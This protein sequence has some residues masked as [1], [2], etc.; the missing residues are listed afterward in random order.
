MCALS[1]GYCSRTSVS[2]AI[3]EAMSTSIFA[4]G[5][6]V[7]RVA[8]AHP[9]KVIDGHDRAAPPALVFLLA[10]QIVIDDPRETR[11]PL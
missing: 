9:F 3:P 7:V 10:A 11:I 5:N 8:S 4:W 6:R 1:S 2:F